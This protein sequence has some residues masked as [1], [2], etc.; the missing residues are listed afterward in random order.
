M[1]ASDVARFSFQA[2][3]RYPL[4]TSMLLLAI[5]IG[6]A[7][8][9]TLT[10]VGEGARRYISGEF[11]DLGTNL[12]IVLPGRSDTAGA[13]LQGMLIGET[14][15]DLTLGDVQAISRSPYVTSV[16]PL[17]IG[18]GAASFRA[19]ERDTTVIG[20]NAAFADIQGYTL[21]K[22]SFLPE[23]D[24][25]VLSP[26]CVLG[27]VVA[28]ELFA[29]TEPLGQ[30]LRI[31]D[32]RCRVIGVLE[33][34]GMTGPFDTDE[35]I[36]VPVANAQQLFNTPSVFRIFVET[37]DRNQ[38]ERA[39]RDIIEIVKRR[40]QGVEDITVI[41]QDAILSTFDDIFGVITAALAGI[42]GISL[43]VAGVLIMNVML[44]AVSQR[45]A[46]IGLLKAL[47]ANRR[48]VLLLFL[49]EASFLSLLGGLIGY[50]VGEAASFALRTAYPI[51]DF[52]APVWAAAAGLGVAVAS[53][54]VFGILPARR[55]ARLDPVEA[56]SK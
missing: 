44:V 43:V 52:Q 55:A 26:V 49:A 17:V 51:I 48:Q 38:M 32:T 45:T 13:G 2:L 6:V 18:S 28:N 46:E 34:A 16:A 23:T 22:G 3:R 47:G 19:R 12:L 11:D 5:A 40:H 14:G 36:V 25:D 9:I 27:T 8:V 21:A 10:S 1:I 7:S 41:S 33:Q 29:T 24:L 15:R 50:G 35:M 31:G 30:W 4:R 56:L 53:G 39:R 42:A 54:L 20:A 37:T